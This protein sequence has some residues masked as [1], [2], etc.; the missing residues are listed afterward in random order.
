MSGA[1]RPFS[2]LLLRLALM[3]KS[4][5]LRDGSIY[6]FNCALEADQLT[7]CQRVFDLTK[8]AVTYP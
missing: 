8:L 5:V 1:S 3:V 7:L 6:L 2:L 4:L